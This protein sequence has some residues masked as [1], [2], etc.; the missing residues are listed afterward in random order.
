MKITVSEKITK[1]D[2]LV[3]PFYKGKKPS[4]NQNTALNN[5][6]AGDFEGNKG[7]TVMLYQKNKITPRI[8]LVGLGE[9]KETDI[10]TWRDA[11]GNVVKHLKKPIQNIAILPP[12][13]DLELVSAFVEGLLL[14]HYQYETFITNEERQK[15]PLKQLHLVV[16]DKKKKTTTQQ[17][18]QETQQTVAAVHYVRDLVNAPSN[19][20][21]PTSLASEAIKIAKSSS[22]ISA[23]IFDE[24]KL[25]RM[26]MGCL[27]GVGAGAKEQSRLII[28]EHKYKPTNKKPIVLIGKGI[29]FDAGGINIKTRALTEMKF[30]MAG[31]A[32]VLGVFKLL[33]EQKLPLHVIGIAACAENML[34]ANA[35]K[36]SD[37][38]TNYNGETVEVTNT[39]AEGRLVLSDAISYAVKKLKPA[40]IIDIATLTGAAIT[41]LGYDYT[42]LMTD[43]PNLREKLFA[44]SKNVDEKLWELPVEE[45]YK[46]YL[47]SP[48]ADVCNY[49]RT[50]NAGTIMGGLFLEHFTKDI[51][52][53]HL[54]IAGSGWT[55]DNKPGFPKGATGRT[56]RTLWDMLKNY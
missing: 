56:V 5:Q 21:N 47:K 55:N 26:G 49:N 7:E 48:I 52:W 4:T 29:C 42:A 28:L 37:V 36:P 11:G 31:A 40:A 46:K 45:S 6:Y 44:A 53:A 54:D 9:Q 18:L 13:D 22:K 34:G 12:K 16:Q 51:P 32:T 43:T 3:I 17:A 10:R 30:D 27:L 1:S 50:P 35:T 39:D 24:S 20:V 41:A 2:L 33:S 19:A 25:K 38:L 8:L 14:G 23:K 15:Q